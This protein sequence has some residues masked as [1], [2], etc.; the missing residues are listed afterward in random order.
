MQMTACHLGTPPGSS[1]YQSYPTLPFVLIQG[2]PGT[3]KTHTVVGVL[4]VWHLTAYQRYY[5][6]LVQQAQGIQIE[7]DT[8]SAS[9]RAPPIPQDQSRFNPLGVL[10][11]G[12]SAD[13]D[14]FDS[15]VNPRRLSTSFDIVLAT[16]PR[17]LVC[18]PSNAACDE[19]LLRVMTSG[20]CDGNGEY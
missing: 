1:D 16:K 8:P 18:A 11:E 13:I 14:I 7:Q 4:N 10:N 9:S 17:I 2:P 5:D 6:R 12:L 19:L 15:R 20:F 3:G